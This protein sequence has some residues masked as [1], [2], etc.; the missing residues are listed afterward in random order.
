MML[1]PL[2]TSNHTDSHISV[3][4]QRLLDFLGLLGLLVLL[5][6]LDLSLLCD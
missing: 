1:G 2:E 6:L 4:S 3:F 5:V